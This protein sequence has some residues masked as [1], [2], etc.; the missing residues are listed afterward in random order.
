MRALALTLAIA[1]SFAHPALAAGKPSDDLSIQAMHN[2]AACVVDRTRHG[3]VSVLAMDFRS[4]EYKTAMKKIAR[5]HDMCTRPGTQIGFG[6]ILLAGGMAERL[7]ATEGEL[8]GLPAAAAAL[9]DAN[10]IEARSASEAVALCVVKAAPDK[11]TG[12]LNTQ[13][14]TSAE[15]QAVSALG[16]QLIGCVPAGQKFELNRPGLRAILALAAY[17][18]VGADTAAG[19]S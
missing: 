14:T 2:F 15:G 17:R 7:M 13:V 8:V 12:L 3:A 6:G 10:P 19:N 16:Q 18:L 5:G 1:V 9:T 11:V 4:S